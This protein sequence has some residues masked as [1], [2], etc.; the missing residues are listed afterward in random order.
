MER[1]GAEK[2]PI[3]FLSKT[4]KELEAAGKTDLNAANGNT[5]TGTA[6]NG[7]ASAS[8]ASTSNGTASTTATTDGDD[9]DV[10]MKEEDTGDGDDA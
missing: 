1:R 4:F 5:D 3:A 8:N 7:S 9:K 10:I 2:Y 6:S